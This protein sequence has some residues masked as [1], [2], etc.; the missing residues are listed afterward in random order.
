M[1][2]PHATKDP[3]SVFQLRRV[4]ACPK[5]LHKERNGRRQAAVPAKAC[6]CVR[7]GMIGWDRALLR[8]EEGGKHKKMYLVYK[9]GREAV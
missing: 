1:R 3:L 4:C 7:A 6:A 2:L 9:K 8:E 5:H